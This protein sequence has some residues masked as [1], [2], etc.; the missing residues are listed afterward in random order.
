MAFGSA[1]R[2][3]RGFELMSTRGSETNG[4]CS[5]PF[6]EYAFRTIEYRIRVTINDDA[7]WAYH[8]D[9]TLLVHGQNEPFH[10]RDRSLLKRVAAPTPNPL[11]Q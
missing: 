7:T 10:H 1:D 2:D 11:A 9:T 3:A 6:L 5:N 8:Q 4:I